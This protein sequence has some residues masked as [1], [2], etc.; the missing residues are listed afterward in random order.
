MTNLNTGVRISGTMRSPVTKSSPSGE[1]GRILSY[2]KAFPAT[3]AG[4]LGT[5]PFLAQV[6]WN[7]LRHISIARRQGCVQREH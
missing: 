5:P 6:S 2:I 3:E 4:K 1:A 7:G